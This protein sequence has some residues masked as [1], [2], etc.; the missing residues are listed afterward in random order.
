M[1]SL[2][3]VISSEDFIKILQA[4]RISEL[5]SCEIVNGDKVIF[6]A[7]IH[8]TDMYASSFSKLQSEALAVKTNITHG[9][10]PAELLTPFTPGLT[11]TDGDGV[12][13][14]FTTKEKRVAGLAKAREVRKQKQL[15]GV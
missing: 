6:T 2:I 11:V 8:S 10:D 9:V 7:I 1:S 12:A 13:H 3:P 14:V 4:G 5:K 15:V